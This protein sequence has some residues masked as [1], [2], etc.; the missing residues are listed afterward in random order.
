MPPTRNPLPELK[1][2]FADLNEKGTFVNNVITIATKA[3]TDADTHFA[4]FEYLQAES[5]YISS[6]DGFMHL[7]KITRDDANFQNYVS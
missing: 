1:S 4:Q 6:L 7:M 2:E 5:E 3:M